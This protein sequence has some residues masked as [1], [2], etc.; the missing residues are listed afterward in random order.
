MDNFL[1]QERDFD[2]SWCKAV[3][4]KA[5]LAAIVFRNVPSLCGDCHKR[6]LEIM[7]DESKQRG[8]VVNIP[9]LAGSVHMRVCSRL[10]RH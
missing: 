9:L 4:G 2:C 1:M 5:P 3:I 10:A 8:D 6:I 7:N